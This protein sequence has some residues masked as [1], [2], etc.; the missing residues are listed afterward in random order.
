MTALD[1]TGIHALEHLANRLHAAGKV[2]LLCGAMH[3]PARLLSRSH[4]LNRLGRE[5]VLPNIDAALERARDI[6][7]ILRA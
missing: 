7:G 3:Q 2:M 5:N 6:D 4:F 1:A